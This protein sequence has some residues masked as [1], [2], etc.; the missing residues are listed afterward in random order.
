MVGT[1]FGRYKRNIFK[2]IPR[3]NVIFRG[4]YLQAGESVI[5]WRENALHDRQDDV[6]KRECLVVGFSGKSLG[7]GI[8]PGF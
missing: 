5:R 2:G 7:S 4:G 8:H 1:V 6:D 3:E